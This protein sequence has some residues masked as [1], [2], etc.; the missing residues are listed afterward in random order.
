MRRWAV[1]RSGKCSWQRSAKCKGPEVGPCPVY[2][3]AVG[4]LY[5][6]S[7]D[8]FREVTGKVISTAVTVLRNH[9]YYLPAD[10]SPLTSLPW[11]GH[12]SLRTGPLSICFSTASSAPHSTSQS[13]TSATSSA[14][15]SL[16]HSLP[17]VYLFAFVILSK[18]SVVRLRDSLQCQFIFLW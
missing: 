8:E 9:L 18:Q 6:W 10:L 16:F 12:E 1:W 3:A 5:G 2:W 17:Q 13:W 4:S 11:L 14:R 7:E 15:P